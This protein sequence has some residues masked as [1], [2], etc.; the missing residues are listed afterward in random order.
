MRRFE[1]EKGFSQ[2]TA[3]LAI[4]GGRFVAGL[5]VLAGP[6]AGTLRMPLLRFFQF[7]FLGAATWVISISTIGY[8]F[9]KH[10]NRLL[11]VIRQTDLVI[12]G[13]VF[14]AAAL[15]Y[16]ERSRANSVEKQADAEKAP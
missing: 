4:F 6:L 10:L 5:R 7:N 3:P 11:E 9:G 13:L 15:W 16:W 12:L 1:K 8:L 2:R 14:I